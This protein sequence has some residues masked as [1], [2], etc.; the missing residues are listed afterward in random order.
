ML[1]NRVIS[2][3]AI[4]PLVFIAVWF[5][6]RWFTALVAVATITASL[7]L[8]HL[9]AWGRR[10]LALGQ[11]L[12][13]VLIILSPEFPQWLTILLPWAFVPGF[14]ILELMGFGKRKPAVRGWGW[15]LTGALFLGGLLGVWI[16]LRRE[17]LGQAWVFIGLGA[18]F[19]CDTAAYF[20]GKKWG[21]N[22]LAPTISPRKTKEGAVG[23]FFGAIAAV[24]FITFL[25]QRF[26]EHPLPMNIIQTALLG[27]LIGVIAQLG[28]L[29][30]SWLKRRS[31]V[32]DSGRLIPGHGGMLDR[33]DSIVFVGLVLYY[34]VIW[35]V[36]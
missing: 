1:R 25:Y 35:A 16:L 18:T 24:F 32:K 7:E 27:C 5:G 30:E 11:A 21:R 6:G 20:V 36:R 4:L 13:I 28:D 17:P 33:L 23:G 26:S 31:G 14:V 8:Y 2:S 9:T 29:G 19:A 15:A 22:R 12:A 3:L 10:Y 34:Y